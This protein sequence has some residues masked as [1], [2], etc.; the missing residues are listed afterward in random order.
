MVSDIKGYGYFPVGNFTD[1]QKAQSSECQQQYSTS[2]SMLCHVKIS[3]TGHVRFELIQIE[4]GLRS[5]KGN[6]SK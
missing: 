6:I 4:E 1:S 2:E 5:I 3:L